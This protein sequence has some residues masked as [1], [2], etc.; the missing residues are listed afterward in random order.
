[1]ISEQEAI[2]ASTGLQ[3]GND[4]YANRV[5]RHYRQRRKWYR[6]WAKWNGVRFAATLMRDDGYPVDVAVRVLCGRA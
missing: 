6:Q 2:G 5:K 1:M 3:F 4:S